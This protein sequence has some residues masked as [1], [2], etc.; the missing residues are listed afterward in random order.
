MGITE[1]YRQEARN[2]G[3]AEDV[4]DKAL[5]LNRPRLELRGPADSMRADSHPPMGRY[6]GLPEL[7]EDVAWT[8]YPHFIAVVDCA[9]LPPDALDIPLPREGRLLFFADRESA[10]PG[11]GGDGEEER[12]G[13]VVHVRP[14]V[15]VEERQ[16][17]EGEREQVQ[18]PRPLYGRVEWHMPGAEDNVFDADPG[19][20]AFLEQHGLEYFGPGGGID[21]LTLGGYSLPVYNDPCTVRWP[22][23]GDEAWVLLA[24]AEYPT[25]ERSDTHAV[26]AWMI[27]RQDLEAEDFSRVKTLQEYW[28]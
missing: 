6:G 14:G 11:C 19:M 21:E 9:A 2:I 10:M 20:L 15:S 3:A 1:G 25:G 23:T 16:P 5:T 4:I 22:E 18:E 26:T 7:P 27:R 13:R 24:Q 8:G 12:A 28:H 17:E